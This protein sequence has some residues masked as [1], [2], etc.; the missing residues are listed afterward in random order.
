MSPPPKPSCSSPVNWRALRGSMWLDYCLSR[1]GVTPYRFAI[2]YMADDSADSRLVSKWLSGKASPTRASVL[3][4]AGLPDRR[5]RA[6]AKSIPNSIWLFDAASLLGPEAPTRKRVT[7]LIDERLSK[8]GASFWRWNFPEEHAPFSYASTRYDTRELEARA[9]IWGLLALVCLMW[10]AELLHLTIH[11][12]LFKT[13]NR[14]ISAII[15]PPWILPYRAA[16]SSLIP[17]FRDRVLLTYLHT[18]SA[19]NECAFG[20]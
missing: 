10:E 16:I 12:E 1:S 13:A 17:S 18:D 11:A 2:D 8:A 9:D 20:S 15:E 14:M 5:H 6:P 7:A 3:R 4:V 19:G